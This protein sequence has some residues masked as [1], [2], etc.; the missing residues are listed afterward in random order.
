MVQQD[1]AAEKAGMEERVEV[2]V[3][4]AKEKDVLFTQDRILIQAGEEMK[5]EVTAENQGVLITAEAAEDLAKAGLST[6]EMIQDSE[7]SEDKHLKIS[8]F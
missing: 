8:D 1:M 2:M 6:K 7:A 3:E 5:E 4:E